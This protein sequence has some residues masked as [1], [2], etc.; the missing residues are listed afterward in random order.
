[1]MADV[2]PLGE[3]L[4]LTAGPVLG[5][6]WLSGDH[7]IGPMASALVVC[8]VAFQR[9]GI[10]RW[11]TA[12]GYYASGSLPVIAAV[13]GY[14]GSG[15]LPIAILSW[16]GASLL[17]SAPWSIA[18]SF[19]GALVALALTALP[20]LGVIGWLS[21]LNA[22]GV[23]FPGLGWIGL[24]AL[25]AFFAAIHLAVRPR[26]AILVVS[27]GLSVVSNLLYA[28]PPATPGWIG[29]DTSVAPSHGDPLKSIRNNESLVDEGVRHGE[30]S[31]VI[32]FP[33]AV[34]DDWLPGTRQELSIAVPAGATWILGA[35]TDF[36]DVIVRVTHGESEIT[37]IARSAGLVLGGNWLPWASRSLRP[38][39]WERV[40]LIDGRRAWAALCV[41]QLQ[42]WVWLEALAQRPEVI[43]AM[44]N[45]WWAKN[46]DPHLEHLADTALLDER[47]STRAWARL[48]NLPVVW[49]I[50]R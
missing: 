35:E 15:A 4:P 1:M 50:N 9:R 39:W 21:P 42:P 29:L 41:E 22:A 23:F 49:A 30:N 48:L 44:S 28:N 45:G 19:P 17:L 31:R 43:L 3:I 46:V 11:L 47:A 37:P 13:I 33:E 18:G 7:L 14:W 32:I 25:L 36:S 20:P 27:L 38:A 40:A 34:L 2:H 12:L 26:L 8:V 6:C 24:G 16:L 10:M 5:A